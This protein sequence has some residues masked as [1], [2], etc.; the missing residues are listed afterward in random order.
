MMSAAG[1][2][3]MR[4]RAVHDLVV[5]AS[6]GDRHAFDALASM[7]VD[8]LYA[9]AHR[10]LRDVDRAEDAVQSALLDAWRD[11]PR[12]REPDR[13]DAWVR[14]LLVHACYDEARRERSFRGTL[15]V[16]TLEPSTSD[17]TSD[18]ADRDELERAFRRLAPE[19]RAVVVLHHYDGLP[20]AEDVLHLRGR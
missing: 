8:R 2:A 15:R 3:A 12:L 10:I 1:V 6:Q 4:G 13:F 7:S 18:L 9:I 5:R 16:L 17:A 20:G 14:R 19:Q 11:L